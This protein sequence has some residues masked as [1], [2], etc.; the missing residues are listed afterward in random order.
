M[1]GSVNCFCDTL[2]KAYGDCCEDYANYFEYPDLTILTDF[3]S[4]Y[5]CASIYGIDS[6]GDRI[7]IVNRCPEYMAR[8]DITEQCEVGRTTDML[9]Q[10]PVSD[11]HGILFKNIFCAL[12]HRRNPVDVL[13]W[14]AD[15]KCHDF[16]KDDPDLDI[17]TIIKDGRFDPYCK[18]HYIAPQ[19]D[20]NFRKCENYVKDCAAEF[21]NDTNMISRC[22]HGPTAF[23]Y[24]GRMTYKNKY[25]AQCNGE[26]DYFCWA[27][28]VRRAPDSAPQVYPLSLLLDLN[29]GFG[30]F[31]SNNEVGHITSKDNKT[32]MVFA[33]CPQNQVYDPFATKCRLVSCGQGFE[34]VDSKCLAKDA[35]TDTLDANTSSSCLRHVLNQTEFT[36]LPSG[37]IY[38]NSSGKTIHE[39]SYEPGPDGSVL[40]CT[41]WTSNYTI[42]NRPF[43]E[44]KFDYAQ[45]VLSITGQVIS[46][47][48][49]AIHFIV[50]LLL[51]HLQNLAGKSLMCLVASLF[52]AQ[53]FFLFG[54]ARTHVYG[55]CLVI[56]IVLHFAFLAAFFWM[57]VMSVDIFRTFAKRTKS[58][59]STHLFMRYSVYAW[60]GPTL[61][62]F[63][64]IMLN[65]SGDIDVNPGYGE[66]VCWIT[67]RWALLFFFAIPVFLIVIINTALY[68]LTTRALCRI[69][70]DTKAV[71][72]SSDKQKLILYVKLSMIMGLTWLFGFVATLT[73]ARALWYLFIILNR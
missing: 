31:E 12:C 28:T 25:C 48:S 14:K 32:F 33:Q 49:L 9:L 57:N 38:V 68:I 23:V 30:Q 46:L 8:N 52:V 45:T 66:G 34:L 47:I 44:F 37:D 65:L 16:T 17:E 62:V 5:E 20:L 73:D 21:A 2:C 39:E 41:N 10:W 26:A 7:H 1:Y 22:H 56:A 61:I 55:L 15:F 24:T 63:I 6:G 18:R 70:R 51:P 59:S 60:G 42:H 53:F 11:K 29:S 54:T 69:A 40:I 43:M 71:S 4:S 72:K 35:N 58:S 19:T 50:Y 3:M 27:E 64:S 13:Y 36:L 67:S